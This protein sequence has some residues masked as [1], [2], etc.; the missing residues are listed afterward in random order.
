MVISSCSVNPR[1]WFKASDAS[2]PGPQ[3]LAAHALAP[4]LY[5]LSQ[6]KGIVVAMTP[7]G[8]LQTE[9]AAG[10]ARR[11]GGVLRA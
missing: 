10:W 4:A 3:T 8:A 1:K 7:G 2:M 5:A 11:T 9:Y 6:W